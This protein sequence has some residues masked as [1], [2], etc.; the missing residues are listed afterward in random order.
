[1]EIRFL[2]TLLFMK[3]IM[4]VIIK[5]DTK[6]SITGLISEQCSAIQGSYFESSICKCGDILNGATLVSENQVLKCLGTNTIQNATGKKDFTL[7]FAALI[8]T[9]FL[10]TH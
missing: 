6:D 8:N 7:I 5:R 2:S 1:M 10:L 3:I 4:C 9:K